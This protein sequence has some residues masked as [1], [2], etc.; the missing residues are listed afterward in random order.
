MCKDQHGPTRFQLCKF[1]S[2]LHSQCCSFE[3]LIKSVN[4][5][6]QSLKFFKVLHL[7]LHK[8][9]FNLQK[10]GLNVGLLT[11]CRSKNYPPT[12]ADMKH[13]MLTIVIGSSASTWQSSHA[14]AASELETSRAECKLWKAFRSS[15]TVFPCISSIC[16][17]LHGKAWFRNVS[18]TSIPN[19]MMK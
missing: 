5:Q 19:G 1:A 10:Y 8:S 4:H 18:Q 13:A 14:A 11:N 3:L 2:K 17:F 6:E 7:G 9:R 16:S 12:S 15:H